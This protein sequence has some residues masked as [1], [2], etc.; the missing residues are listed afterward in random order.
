V[1][2]REEF[3]SQVAGESDDYF[4]SAG[5]YAIEKCGIVAQTRELANANEVTKEETGSIQVSKGL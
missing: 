1:D 4:A 5:G 2:R 3:A